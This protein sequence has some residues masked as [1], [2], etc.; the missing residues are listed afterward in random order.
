M[1]ESSFIL[2]LTNKNKIWFIKNAQPL[3][4]TVHLIFL[5]YGFLILKLSKSAANAN[6][7]S[8]KNGTVYPPDALRR[9]LQAVAIN[10]AQMRLQFIMPKLVAKCFCP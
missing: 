1:T 9:L 2:K 8:N 6:T 3:H 4:V 5:G 7:N 10:E